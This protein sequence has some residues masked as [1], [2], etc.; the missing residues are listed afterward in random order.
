MWREI[1]RETKKKKKNL[2]LSPLGGRHHR[3]NHRAWGTVD[4]TE[5]PF[6]TDEVIKYPCQRVHITDEGKEDI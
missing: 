1:P 4:E 3:D 6:V 2:K 5:K